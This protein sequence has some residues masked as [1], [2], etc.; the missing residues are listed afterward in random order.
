MR[1]VVIGLPPPALC[2]EIEVLRRPLNRLVGAVQALRYPPHLTLRTGLVCPDDRADEVSRGFLAHAATLFQAPVAT[3]GLFYT[4][5]GV[6][7]DKRG[8]VGWSVLPSF[9]LLALHQGLLEY[10]AWQKGPQNGFQP[11]LT[12]A[13]DDLSPAG[14]ETLRA[15]LARRSEPVPDFRW[16]LDR[17]SLY[18]ELP[19][20]WVEWNTA[21]LKSSSPPSNWA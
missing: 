21:A 11:H 8:M 4:T 14:V 1:F 6:P 17:V 15:E 10:S 3:R 16:T 7:E 19:G 9:E 13:F 20:G 12:L 18:H 5:Y 2:D